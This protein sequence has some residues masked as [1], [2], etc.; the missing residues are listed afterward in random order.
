MIYNIVKTCVARFFKI[1]FLMKVDGSE[2]VPQE[3]GLLLCSN[4]QSNWDPPAVSG[5]FPRRLSIMAK[6]E[7]FHNPIFGWMI[8]TLGAYPIRRG[9][10]DAGAILAT[11]K[12]LEAGETTLVF[13]EGTRVQAGGGDRKINSGIIR[14]AIK[15]Q[16]PIVPAYTN[17]KYR[18]FG[19]LRVYFGKPISYEQYYDNAPDAETL[20]RLA[21]ELM[22]AIYS[23]SEEKKA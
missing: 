8:K 2:N 13:P 14:I 22:E 3:G 5:A 19:K 9:K 21:Q 6:E 10:G 12:L 20:D 15:A 17:G 1:A 7:L 4:H 11:L 18:L 23:F 16:V